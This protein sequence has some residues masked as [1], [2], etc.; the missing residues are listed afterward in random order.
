MAWWESLG[1]WKHAFERGSQD[2][3]SFTPGE[4]S[5][6]APQQAP[7]TGCLH[8][9]FSSGAQSNEVNWPWTKTSKIL[10]QNEIFSFYKILFLSTRSSQVFIAVRH[11]R[12]TTHL[13]SH[14]S[15]GHAG[16]VKIRLMEGVPRDSPSVG[17]DLSWA[18]SSL[19]KCW[20]GNGPA[21]GRGGIAA[22]EEALLGTAQSNR[23]K[24]V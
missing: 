8:Q 11:S 24:E 16:I 4:V 14:E 21:A 5:I 19:C 7:I 22:S 12:P 15:R 1:C 6:S 18:G 13:G 10:G 23:R 9:P 17:V 2:S 20:G 3:W